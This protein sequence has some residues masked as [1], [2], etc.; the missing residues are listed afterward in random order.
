MNKQAI[1]QGLCDLLESEIARATEAAERTR[2]DATHEEAKPEN[3]KDTRALEQTYLARGQAQ[4]VVELQTALK[5]IKFMDVRTFGAEDPIAVSA[6]VQLQQADSSD[7]R[8]YFLAPVAGGRRVTVGGTT[9]D[10]I[11]PEAPLGRALASRIRDDEFVVRSGGRAVE[12]AICD[13]L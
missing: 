13:V 3:D 8:W 4:R 9:V 11:T 5:Q 12:W 10:I 6:L 7:L 1:I 2:A